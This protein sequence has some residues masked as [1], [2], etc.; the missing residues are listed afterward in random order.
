[1]DLAALIYELTR[2]FPKHEQYGLTSQLCRAAVSVPSNIAEGHA[3]D[4][5]KEYLHHVSF[6]MGS[7]AEVETQI[8]LAERLGYVNSE[9]SNSTITKTAELGRRLRALQQSLK[10]KAL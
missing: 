5:T 8:L 2:L 1:M 6:A 10:T 3:R 7:L 9:I 4:S